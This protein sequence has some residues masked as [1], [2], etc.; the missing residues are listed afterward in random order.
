M[1]VLHDRGA[2]PAQPSCPRP[3]PARREQLKM[4]SSTSCARSAFAHRAQNDQFGCRQSGRAYRPAAAPNEPYLRAEWRMAITESDGSL[5]QFCAW[6]C[7]RRRQSRHGRARTGVNWQA[8]ACA[9]CCALF[10]AI[11][12][13]PD[14]ARQRLLRLATARVRLSTETRIE[15]GVTTRRT[16][17]VA[18]NS[19]RRRSAQRRMRDS[20]SR[21]VAP[22]TLSNNADRHSSVSATVRGMR[23]RYMSGRG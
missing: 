15:T 2:A 14:Q 3:T 19:N 13:A 8:H 7:H 12:S 11:R 1:R 4:L 9:A 16:S 17:S 22:N 6:A 21:G 10:G 18:S 5:G 20:N 23:K